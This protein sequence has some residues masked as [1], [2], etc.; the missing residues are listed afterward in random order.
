MVGEAIRKQS[1]KQQGRV[2]RR[3]R[4]ADALAL[5]LIRVVLS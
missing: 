2:G 4:S 3:R 1:Q 5:S